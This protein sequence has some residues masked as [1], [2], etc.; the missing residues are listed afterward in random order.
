MNLQALPGGLFAPR[1][2]KSPTTPAICWLLSQEILFCP[3][4]APL[5]VVL[6]RTTDFLLSGD[7][8]F[9]G[10]QDY[11]KTKSVLK[12]TRLKAEAKKNSSGFRVNL[13]SALLF[14]LSTRSCSLCLC[15]PSFDCLTVCWEPN[16]T[17]PPASTRCCISIHEGQKWIFPEFCI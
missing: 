3:H 9:L 15:Q 17:F 16:T 1:P 13:R 4:T 10:K 8:F 2:T 5:T 6:P 7:F 11:K 12:A 14:T